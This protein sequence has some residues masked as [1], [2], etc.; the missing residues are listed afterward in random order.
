MHI[1]LR[2]IFEIIS[3]GLAFYAAYLWYK[4][5][6][7]TTP[8]SFSIH[9]VKPDSGPFGGN[10]LGSTYMGQGYSEDLTNLGQ[11]LSR[12]GKENAKA[13]LFAGFAAI[14][15]GFIIIINLL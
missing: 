11:S 14:T 5:S 3:A 13:A 12:Q 1:Y 6:K 15:Q 10:P 8:E 7:I 9:V 2:I 4:A